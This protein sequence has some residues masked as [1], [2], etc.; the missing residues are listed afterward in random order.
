MKKGSEDSLYTTHTEPAPILTATVHQKSGTSHLTSASDIVFDVAP[1]MEAGSVGHQ[2]H[3]H[4]SR[5]NTTTYQRFTTFSFFNAFLPSHMAKKDIHSSTSSN[6][7]HLVSKLCYGK[8]VAQP[9]KQA[10][11]S[12]SCVVS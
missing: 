1:E 4:K 11:N 12:R 8:K 3:Q 10:R 2:H 7:R 9:A 6:K 5:E